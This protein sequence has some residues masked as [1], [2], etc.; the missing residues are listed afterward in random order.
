MLPVTT[1]LAY[2][3]PART[4]AI[5]W[6]IEE[7]V[8]TAIKA[9]VPKN[10]KRTVIPFA[11]GRDRRGKKRTQNISTSDPTRM[12]AVE[13]V[14]LLNKYG[15]D[16]PITIVDGDG[17][18]LRPSQ[19]TYLIEVAL[20]DNAE[21]VMNVKRDGTFDAPEKDYTQDGDAGYD[22]E[23]VDLSDDGRDDDSDRLAAAF[24]AALA[25][26]ETG[27]EAEPEAEPEAVAPSPGKP[28]R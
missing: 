23:D 10:D 15:K 2:E 16:R 27:D 9:V 4:Q 17:R 28:R 12:M 24:A 1:A 21:L 5:E 7:R 19:Q 22:E 14:Q 25:A 8:P 11:I 3:E 6:L 18:G 20:E 13:A 26:A